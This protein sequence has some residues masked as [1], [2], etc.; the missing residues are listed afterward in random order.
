VIDEWLALSFGRTRHE[1]DGERK[2]RGSQPACAARMRYGE[3]H[4]PC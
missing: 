2:G 4:A 1:H 3:W